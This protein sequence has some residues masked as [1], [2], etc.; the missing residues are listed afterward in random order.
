[1]THAAP[2]HEKRH[3]SPREYFG[4]RVMSGARERLRLH[5]EIDFGAYVGGIDGAATDSVG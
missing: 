2:A 5:V 1:L 3:R 4:K